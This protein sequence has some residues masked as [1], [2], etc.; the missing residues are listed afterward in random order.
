MQGWS[1]RRL[2]QN[3]ACL[4]LLSSIAFAQSHDRAKL[5]KDIE[6][7]RDQLRQ[8]EAEFLS[9]A[10]E[11]RAQ[12]ADF[13]HQTGTGLAR[14]LPREKYREK[15]SVREGGAYFSFT[16]L[17]NSYD[18]DP[19]LGLEQEQL[20]TGFAGANFG[21]LASLGDTPLEN[22]NMGDPSV[23]YLAAFVTPTA[24][25]EQGNSNGEAVPGL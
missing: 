7:L 15:L 14:L 20:S 24:E 22:V 11:D 18:R 9:A 17:S 10:P 8:K 23:Q 12:F 16:K 13:L 1:L 25:P 4:V 19:Q 3:F 21:F 6:T 5:E 2:I